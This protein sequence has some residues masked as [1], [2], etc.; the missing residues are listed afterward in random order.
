M[1]TSAFLLGRAFPD[2]VNAAGAFLIDA[3]QPQGPA[4][5]NVRSEAIPTGGAEPQAQAPGRPSVNSDNGLGRPMPMEYVDLGSNRINATVTPG[6][7]G[8]VN[9]VRLSY[10]AKQSDEGVFFVKDD[11]AECKAISIHHDKPTQLIIMVPEGLGSGRCFL[12]VRSRCGE[13][14]ALKRGRLEAELVIV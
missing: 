7:M 1:L 12:E 6:G 4:L 2:R 14:E 8:L 3:S 13:S 11:G 5:T 9:G 10:D